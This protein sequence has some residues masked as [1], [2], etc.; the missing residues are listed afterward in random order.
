MLKLKKKSC[1][2]K[3]ILFSHLSLG[4]FP[5]GF[6]TKT[7]HTPLLTPIR[8]TRPTH[9]ILL[10]FFV[11]LILGMEYKSL[12][13]S[14]C[15]FLRSP[16]TSSL[17]GPNILLNTLYSNTVCLR[18]FRNTRDHVSHPYKTTGKIIFLYI[19]IFVLLDNKV[20]DQRS[21]S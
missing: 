11:R 9:L 7:L 8:A 5:S 4:L 2:K 17:L 18:S 14:L 10:Y 19:I 12:S 6:P 13:C 16:V 3:L 15:S 1:A 21:C 20:E